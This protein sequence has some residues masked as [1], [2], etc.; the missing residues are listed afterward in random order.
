VV[1]GRYLTSP[2]QAGSQSVDQSNEGA[3]K[4]AV[5]VLDAPVAKS[6]AENAAK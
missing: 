3:I 5:K 6:R 1:N 2:A 4:A